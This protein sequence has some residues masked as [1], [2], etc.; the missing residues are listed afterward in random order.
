MKVGGTNTLALS[1]NKI[2]S[3]ADVSNDVLGATVTTEATGTMN[4]GCAG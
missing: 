3:S 4:E 2:S 1:G